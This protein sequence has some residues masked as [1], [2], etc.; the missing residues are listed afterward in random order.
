MQTNVVELLTRR[1]TIA[2]AFRLIRETLR[3]VERAFLAPYAVPCAHVGSDAT[4]Q[5]PL[6]KVAVAVR[7]IGSH[8]RGLLPLPLAEASNHV[9]RSY[10]FLA[11]SSRGGLHSHDHTAVIV[12]QIVV[13]ITQPGRRAA[14]GGISGIGIG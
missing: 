12:H 7:G 5:Q 1:A 9:L 6:Q 14:F 10:R 2:V 3:A 11:K 8:R 13:V 4:I